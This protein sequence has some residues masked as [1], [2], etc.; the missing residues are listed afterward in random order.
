MGLDMRA[1]AQPPR[2]AGGLEPGDVVRHDI[3]INDDCGRPVFAGDGLFQI[4][5]AVF[6]CLERG[7]ISPRA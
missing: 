5:H 2:F 6:L 7:R 3:Q 4:G 1:V